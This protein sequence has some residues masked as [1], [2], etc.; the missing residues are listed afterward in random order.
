M[1]L[2]QIEKIFKRKPKNEVLAEKDIDTYL[3]LLKS[4]EEYKKLKD[5]ISLSDNVRNL[6]AIE[7]IKE[8][9][10]DYIEIQNWG[11]LENNLQKIWAIPLISTEESKKEKHLIEIKKLLGIN[12]PKVDFFKVHEL[13]E[14]KTDIDDE[15]KKTIDLEEAKK[16]FPHF[17]DYLE[18]LKKKNIFPE[19][20][21]E[22]TREQGKEDYP[23]LIYPV[24]DPIFIH[25]FREKGKEVKYYVIE[26]FLS[27]KEK[28]VYDDIVEKLLDLAYKEP[29]PDRLLTIK[30][31]LLKLLRDLI[32]IDEREEKHLFNVE[33]KIKLTPR[34]YR[35]LKYFLI[36]DRIGY[37]KLEPLFYDP[38]LEDIHCTGIGHISCVHKIFGMVKTNLEFKTDTELNKY[39]IEVT[40]RVERPTSDRHSVVDAMMPD[41]SRSNFI[42]GRDVSMEGSSFTIRKFSK[43][44]VSVTQ[45]INWGTMNSQL[46]AYIWIALENGMSLFVCGETASGKTT[47]LNAI[48]T[49]I[50]PDAKVYTVENTPEVT[51]PHDIWQHL[52]T[53]ESGKTEKESDVT[54]Q[55]LLLAALRSRPNYIIVGEIRGAEGSIA[56]QGM[57]TGHPVLST[58]H[59][60]NVTT[61]IQRLTGNPINIPIAFIDNLNL[62][63]IQQAVYYGNKFVRRIISLSELERYYAP[64]NKVITREVFSRNPITDK[65]LF[66]GLFN[67][68]ILEQKIARVLGY[69]DPRKIY[70]EVNFRRKILDKMVEEGIFN[71]F[72]VWKIIKNFYNGGKESLPF[73]I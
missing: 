46:A 69:D 52:V 23:N 43:V 55:D 11:E 9:C 34:E 15:F 36:R 54:Y 18:L 59:A 38:H 10:L 56:F 24:G 35:K 2:E 68:Y 51:M 12:L 39:I 64:A 14:K 8:K 41:G 29:V 66:R 4:P 37:G 62:C 27:E 53:R 61:L 6:R 32:V 49:F 42:F 63:L 58:F 65:L 48:S 67:S 70:E 28:R 44:P 16:N 20:Y 19:F 60:G 13:H 57:Q 26:P 40:E 25:V 17:N 50:K 3:D 73:K 7:S 71:Y 22:V 30:T 72:E 47:T 33:D 21:P 5:E 1:N 31:I 45:L